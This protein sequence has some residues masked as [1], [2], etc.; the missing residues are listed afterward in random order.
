MD[1]LTV[2]QRVVLRCQTCFH[3]GGSW[4]MSMSNNWAEMS[5]FDY[6]WPN[7][8]LLN[9]WSITVF[10][11]NIRE[12]K[13]KTCI[14]RGGG[15]N[16]SIA[17]FSIYLWTV[18]PTAGCPMSRTADWWNSDL[19]CERL[20]LSDQRWVWLIFLVCPALVSTC[21]ATFFFFFFAFIARHFGQR[22]HGWLLR[23]YLK[24][25]CILTLSNYRECVIKAQ[26]DGESWHLVR[27]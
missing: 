2:N 12:N 23:E 7:W 10:N 14:F 19:L 27:D 24:V 4:N 5:P 8:V 6:S 20:M 22:L 1:G 25:D 17:C 11:R 15:G 3:K 18:L 16:L 9:A 26:G 13:D 21:K